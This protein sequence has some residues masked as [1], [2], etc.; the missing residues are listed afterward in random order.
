MARIL[1]VDDESAILAIL[2]RMLRKLGHEC[3]QASNGKEALR[4]LGDCTVDLVI[5]DLIMPDTEGIETIGV[6][7]KR[8]PETK[9]IAM[10]G[11]G[12]QSPTPYLAVAASLGA[13][14]TL[15]KPFQMADLEMA[16]RAVLAAPSSSSSTPRP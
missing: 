5:T 3:V 7:R 13:D 10:S 12:R 16:L 6:I 14:A 4:T 11:G 8:W 2:D 1:I 15:A 9:I